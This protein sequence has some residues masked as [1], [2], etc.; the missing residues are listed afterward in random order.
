MPPPSF[1][2]TSLLWQ[3]LFEAAAQTLVGAAGHLYFAKTI[4]RLMNS[5]TF[6]GAMDLWQ[7]GV[8]GD[9]ISEGDVVHFDGLIS[10]YIQLFPGDPLDNAR[11]WNSLYSFPGKISS[12]EY[13]SLEF[14]AGSDAALRIGSLNGESL[15]GL[16]SRYGFVGEGMLGV[17][18]TKVLRKALP[19]FFS[20]DFIGVRA[21]VKGK[22]SRCPSQ[23]G[24]VA[25]AIAQRA[26]IP[27]DV[28]GYKNT[29]YLQV[30]T[31]QPYRD[32][33]ARS[34]SLLGSVWAAT[35]LKSE[36]YLVQ[37]G[38]FTNNDE[39]R[40]CLENLRQSKAWRRVRVYFDD[41]DCPSK[42]LSFA[43]QFMS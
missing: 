19:D 27:L 31:I 7:R 26:G 38:Y 23:H 11:R 4:E 2:G 36:Q 22:L 10:P 33:E 30:I 34:I 25:Q 29:W 5:R 12:A 1:P 20:S 32:P 8:R 17:V 14:F 35:E 43:K 28:S 42:D 13:Q 24:Y 18:P 16:Y 41:I 37:Y 21:R 39:R 6:D 40:E 3:P 15:V 9:R